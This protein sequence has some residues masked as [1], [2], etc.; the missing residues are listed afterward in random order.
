[1]GD[2]RSAPGRDPE[3]VRGLIDQLR[4]VVQADGGDLELVS[5]DTATGVVRVRLTGACSSCAIS[6][7]TIQLGVERILKSRF[8]WI[9]SV[10]G[11][12]EE[13]DFETSAALGRGGWVPLQ[14]RRS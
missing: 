6:T 7:S 4:P 5:V 1:M 13:L 9:T 12:L 8:P 2:R 10:E 11:E 14:P 3:A